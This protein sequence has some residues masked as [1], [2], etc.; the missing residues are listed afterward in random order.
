LVAPSSRRPSD[1]QEI[2]FTRASIDAA[3]ETSNPLLR[4]QGGDALRPHFGTIY[5]R[6]L[7][8]SFLDGIGTGS[9]GGICLASATRV[10]E[11][12]QFSFVK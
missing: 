11:T 1:A 12:F 3:V 9:E 7:L 2:A 4:S 6:R 10:K 5:F 8:R